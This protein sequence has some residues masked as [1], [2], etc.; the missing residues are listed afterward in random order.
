MFDSFS[1]V[2]TAIRRCMLGPEKVKRVFCAALDLVQEGYM[3]M[4]DIGYRALFGSKE[5]KGHIN[6]PLVFLE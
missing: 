1:K 2:A 4:G 3:T 6:L 5:K